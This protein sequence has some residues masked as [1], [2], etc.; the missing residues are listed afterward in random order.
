M[1]H[2]AAQKRALERAARKAR[3]KLIAWREAQARLAHDLLA[4]LAGDVRAELA[5]LADPFGRIPMHN[6]PIIRAYLQQRLDQFWTRWR[7]LLDDSLLQAA[8]IGSSLV[9]L[10][11]S[12]NTAVRVSEGVME[13]LRTWRAMDGLT[14]SDRLWRIKD[15]A[16]RILQQAVE[17][18]ILRGESSYAAAQRYL[19]EDLPI[20]ADL[21]SEIQA[22]GIGNIG[23]AVETLLL[24]ADGDVFYPV[25]RVL[26]T[27]INR[28]YTEAYVASIAL[29]PQVEGVRFN[30]SPAHPRPDIC[31][32]YASANL[33][34]LG[35]GVYPPG[36]HPYPAHPNT[37]SYLT[38]VF[39]DEVSDSDRASR[40]DPFDWLQSQSQGMRAAVLGGEKK[41][42]A[43]DA[44]LLQPDELR[45]P[46]YRIE[47]RLGPQA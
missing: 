12:P 46:W 19:L 15:G 4:L 1:A 16:E 21:Q 6:L 28:A 10:T 42:R 14:L 40:Q 22:G 33:H 37:L 34:G 39:T 45:Q 17:G 5:A 3:G 24:D 43:F 29:H 27:E 26:R 8:G 41:A 25:M 9:G 31:D 47:Q 2:G 18:A 32:L 7:Q 44:G 36:Q 23:R 35:P 38:T 20:P 30:L 13:Y 11:G